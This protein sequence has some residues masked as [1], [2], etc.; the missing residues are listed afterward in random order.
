MSK[1]KSPQYYDQTAF[2]QAVAMEHRQPVEEVENENNLEAPHQRKWLVLASVVVVLIISVLG[3]GLVLSLSRN[4]KVSEV[5]PQQQVE[6]EE[7][8]TP[9]DRELLLFERNIAEADPLQ[10]SLAFPPVNFELQLEDA[11][12]R[13]QADY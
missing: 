11:T 13:Q 12:V 7:E 5:T 8:I 9:I 10:S 6:T 1:N 3:L 4:Q 2:S